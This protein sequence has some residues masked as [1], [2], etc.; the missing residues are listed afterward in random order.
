M[1]ARQREDET[2]P[3]DSEAA[4]TVPARRRRAITDRE[5]RALKPGPWLTDPAPRGAGVLQARRVGG[6]VRFYYRYTTDHGTRER[7]SL[8]LYDPDGRAGLTLA[9]ARVAAGERSRQYQ[10]GD[11]NLRE[12]AAR[13]DEAR[14][15]EL[16]AEREAAQRERDAAA[17]RAEATV[18]AL[19]EAYA[20]Y[21]D[22]AGKS[23]HRAA[24]ATLRRWVRD[25]WPSL[26]SAAAADVTPPQVVD[27]L[28]PLVE[29]GK[30]RTANMVRGYLR[31]AYALAVSARL[32]ADAPAAL[33]RLGLTTN[34]VRDVL[35]VAGGSVAKD[36]AL[37]VAELRAYWRAL[38]AMPEPIASGLRLHLLTGGQ[39]WQQLARTTTADLDPDAR[40]VR[41]LDPKGR[42]S[43]ARAHWVPLLPAAESAIARMRAADAGPFLL[44]FTGG[45]SGADYARARREVAEIAAA[46]VARGEASAPFTLGDLRRTVET[47]LAEARVPAD[48]RAH[49]QSHGLGGVQARHYDRWDRAPEVR[50]ALEKLVEIV[51]GKGASVRPFRRNA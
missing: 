24:R 35:P 30:A 29:A 51:T 42:R 44:S 2:A 33:R 7:L 50:A 47:R 15:L 25:R 48:V 23:S 32:R 20:D 36:R 9:Q 14:R 45:R 39:R 1:A 6:A 4:G 8:G 27:V 31:A 38:D 17:L 21:L 37:T 49:L 40:A 22:A 26:W 5:L 46:M 43:V 16:R 13:A 12:A 19:A 3:G 28:L 34:P 11:R 18:G 41:L 10:A